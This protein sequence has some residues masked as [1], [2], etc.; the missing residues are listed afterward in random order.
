MRCARSCEH[1]QVSSRKE[2]YGV[3][4]VVKCVFE[5]CVCRVYVDSVDPTTR[6]RLCAGGILLGVI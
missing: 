2:R 3:I 1:E 6:E 5:M 4:P